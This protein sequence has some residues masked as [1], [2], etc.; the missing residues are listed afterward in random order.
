[1]LARKLAAEFAGTFY[2]VAII[3]TV[4]TRP[5][6][7]GA[8]PDALLP[9]VAIG[10]GLSGLIYALGPVS[11]AHFN[12]AVSVTFAVAGDISAPVAAAY[13]IVQLIAGFLAALAA[14]GISDVAP[15]PAPASGTN[16]TIARAFWAEALFTS[17]LVL[18]IMRI[19]MTPAGRNNHYSGTAIG[20]VVTTGICA[21]GPVS[22][23]V[24]N[25]AVGSGLVLAQCSLG[26]CG[27]VARHLWVYWGGPL[28]GAAIGYGL[29]RA[30]SDTTNEDI[31]PDA[32]NVPRGNDA[33]CS[34]ESEA[35]CIN[36]G[37]PSSEPTAE[38]QCV[39][40]RTCR[41]A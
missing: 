41:S 12:P 29:F 37:A 27:H 40:F 36:V 33:F 26:P 38:G 28:V 15:G 24:F 1:M 39:R 14:A 11:K 2:L 8:H 3:A 25:P 31:T 10:V 7:P 16:H 23:A 18:V 5:N 4:I 21:V 34:E 19:A 6:P 22:G 13:I 32:E 35:I 9:A 20:A 17:M 30:V